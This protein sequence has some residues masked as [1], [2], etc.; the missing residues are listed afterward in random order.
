MDEL[1][2]ISIEQQN[3]INNLNN[4]NVI[5]ESVAG[6]GKTTTN[7]FIAKSYP[8]TNILLLTYNSKLKIETRQKVINHKIHNIEVH[9]YH[10]FCVK[11]Y[12]NKCFTD[13]EIIRLLKDKCKIT[14][15]IFYDIIILDEAQDINPLYYELIHKIFSDNNKNAKI[16]LLGDRYQ[17]IYDF[18]NADSRFIIYAEKLFNFNNFKWEKTKLTESFRITYEMS[19]FINN[20]MLEEKRIVSNKITNNKP[21]YIICDTFKSLL[22]FNEIKYYLDLGYKPDDIFVLAPSIKNVMCPTRKLEN[23]LKT[24]LSNIPVY[25]PTSDE[26]KLDE[27]ILK[28]K[29]VF[30][31]F[32]QSKGLERKDRTVRDIVS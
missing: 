14:K 17:S 29:L 23:I 15:K 1:P 3:V 24:K 32:H 5:V 31:T 25:V 8:N 21:R 10:S 20:C 9:S 2:K 7:L 12:N 4:D 11:Y 27:D 16:C 26:E 6:S 28:N 13:Y 22:P 30:S 18:N 19:E